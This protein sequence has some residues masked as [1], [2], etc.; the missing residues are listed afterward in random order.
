MDLPFHETVTV[1]IINLKL[2]IPSIKQNQ[3][4]LRFL[5]L[6]FKLKKAYVKSSFCLRTKINFKTN[7]IFWIVLFLLILN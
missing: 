1:I 4:L 2:L 7:L 6:E 3:E 5:F